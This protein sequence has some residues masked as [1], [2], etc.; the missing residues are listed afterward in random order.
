MMMVKM[1]FV[2]NTYGVTDGEK[3]V[4]SEA[5][6]APPPIKRRTQKRSAAPPP[7]PKRRKKNS[8]TTGVGVRRRVT[9][10]AR[11]RTLALHLG[12][13]QKNVSLTFSGW[14][15]IS[16]WVTPS[17]SGLETVYSTR[18]HHIFG[19]GVRWRNR[20]TWF[21]HHSFCTKRRPAT[22]F[23]RHHPCLHRPVAP[24]LSSGGSRIHVPTMEIRTRR[25][26]WR[27]HG[28]RK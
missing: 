20:T 26:P 25:H 7:P 8:S 18:T 15:W 19:V 11:P 3:I 9:A 14:R 27:R 21:W 1:I 13:F 6:D 10:P 2:F 17:S 28:S 5:E 22:E 23:R 24:Q 4:W 16:S 12:T